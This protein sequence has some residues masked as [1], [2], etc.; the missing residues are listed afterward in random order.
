[1]IEAKKI[2]LLINFFTTYPPAKVC[3]LSKLLSRNKPS[4]TKTPPNEHYNETSAFRLSMSSFAFPGESASVKSRS[5][6]SAPEKR[7]S[8]QLSFSSKN[9]VP[10]SFSRRGR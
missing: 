10:F 2:L 1:M 8:A 9:L 3:Y 7:S 4:C 5:S 6:G